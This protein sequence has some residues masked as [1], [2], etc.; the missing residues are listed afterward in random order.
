MRRQW[1]LCITNSVTGE[2]YCYTRCWLIV[3]FVERVTYHSKGVGEYIPKKL[4]PSVSQLIC[5]S[6]HLSVCTTIFKRITGL[7]FYLKSSMLHI[8]GIVPTSSTKKWEPFFKLQI[9]FRIDGRIQNIIQTNSEAWILIKVQC[10]LYQWISFDT[11][12]K[13][14]GSFFQFG[15]HFRITGRKTKNI[16]KDRGYCFDNYVYLFLFIFLS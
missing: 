1:Y 8:D 4:I 7:S 3:R 13:Q 6:V 14:I 11:L 10:V 5:L 9:R 16:Q 12:Y 2:I 15:N